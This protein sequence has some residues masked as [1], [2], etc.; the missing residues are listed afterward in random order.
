M[1]LIA[2]LPSRAALASPSHGDPLRLPGPMLF[3]CARNARASGASPAH[4]EMFF[5]CSDLD[6]ADADGATS[7]QAERPDYRSAEPPMWLCVATKTAP[8]AYLG[9][10][11]T[12]AA[13]ASGSSSSSSSSS[14]PENGD[15]GGFVMR[16]L[17]EL[18]PE[19]AETTQIC[20]NNEATL[21]AVLGPH[22]LL[23]FALGRDGAHDVIVEKGISLG[24]ASPR[25]S[26]APSQRRPMRTCAWHPLADNVLVALTDEC[27]T[28]YYFWNGAIAAGLD[29]GV[30][31]ADG[32]LSDSIR[33]EDGTDDDGSSLYPAP[34]RIDGGNGQWFYKDDVVLPSGG[35]SLA[36]PVARSRPDRKPVD[37]CFGDDDVVSWSAF[38]IYVMYGSG[39]II[40]ACPIVPRGVFIQMDTLHE[41]SRGMGGGNGMDDIN[42]NMPLPE[43]RW[44]V[45]DGRA[46][47][48]CKLAGTCWSEVSGEHAARTTSSPTSTELVSRGFLC[49]PA[50]PSGDGT[51]ERPTHPVWALLAGIGDRRADIDPGQYK[52]EV[53]ATSLVVLRSGAT[54][55]LHVAARFGGAESSGWPV[56]LLMRAWSNGDVDLNIAQLPVPVVPSRGGESHRN[57]VFHERDPSF[58]TMGDYSIVGEA[59]LQDTKDPLE[60]SGLPSF[61]MVCHERVHVLILP[62]RGTGSRRGGSDVGGGGGRGDVSATPTMGLILDGIE[63]HAVYAVT[64]A[65]AHRIELDRVHLDFLCADICGDG[66]GRQSSEQKNALC[67]LSGTCVHFTDLSGPTSAGRLGRGSGAMGSI[68]GFALRTLRPGDHRIR[69]LCRDGCVLQVDVELVSALPAVPSSFAA[70]SGMSGSGSGP[71]QIFYE[72]VNDNDPTSRH[73]DSIET[74][75]EKAARQLRQPLTGPGTEFRSEEDAAEHVIKFSMDLVS[76]RIAPWREVMAQ[77]NDRRAK[78]AVMEEMIDGHI[79]SL[80]AKTNAITERL[81]HTQAVANEVRKRH[82]DLSHRARVLLDAV[83]QLSRVIRPPERAWFDELRERS[84]RIARMA[85]KFGYLQVAVDN[86]LNKLLRTQREEEEMRQSRKKSGEQTS[87]PGDRRR[88]ARRLRAAWGGRP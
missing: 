26:L 18:G 68:E 34:A 82:K 74:T 55:K 76:R 16:R 88:R 1:S 31:D 30:E 15:G 41:L 53:L 25:S 85:R 9:G 4:D 23:V 69:L 21:L 61:Q 13:F 40:F 45:I 54:R 10:A 58:S 75:F 87:G 11:K 2:R 57:G 28:I 43:F 47:R 66:R 46:A 50:S 81:Q 3:A 73:R 51:P 77:V 80:L 32:I 83:S 62:Q 70:E 29:T 20:L 65:E 64:A 48:V 33:T 36:S 49:H 17:A 27:L 6:L 79:K 42:N 67:I 14:T 52:R 86:N 39:H 12:S 84:M 7:S 72:V 22:S 35:S 60:Q 44:E 5:V 78:W 38:S 19:A 24:G 71:G 56:T 59:G 37:F 63:D 8:T